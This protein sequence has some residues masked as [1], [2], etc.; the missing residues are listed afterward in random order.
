MGRDKT[1]VIGLDG[2]TFALLKL[3]LDAGVLPNI[4]SFIRNG[5]TGELE[6]VFPPMTGPG[7]VS[8]MTG[9]NPGMHSIFDFFDHSGDLGN[10]RLNSFLDIKSETVWSIISRA[11]KSV[12]LLN[13]P[14]TYPP[15]NINGF[16]VS[17]LLTPGS[18]TDYSYPPDLSG[19]LERRFGRLITEVPWQRYNGKTINQLINHLRDG[20]RQKKDYSIY[21]MEKFDPDIFMVVFTETDSIQHALWDVLTGDKTGRRS[22]CDH[23][24]DQALEYFRELDEA[25]GEIYRSSGE[26][27]NLFIISDHGFGPINKRIHLNAWLSRIGLLSVDRRK[28]IFHKILR[29]PLYALKRF[30]GSSGLKSLLKRKGTP[31][32]LGKSLFIDSLLNCVDW[33]NTKAFSG[34]RT[35]QGIYVNLEGR[36]PCGKVRPGDEYEKLRDH[37]IAELRG[38]LDIDCKGKYPSIIKK[39]EE[40]F[41]G[42][43]L[44]QAPDIVFA[45]QDF[46]CQADDVITSKIFEDRSWRIGTGTH[47]MEGLF[48][49]TG[50][51]IRKGEKT[52]GL[53]IIDIT[54]ILLYSLGLDIPD[55][56]DGKV[57]EGIFTDKYISYHPIKYTKN[58]NGH[59]LSENIVFSNNEEQQV[60]ERLT[61]LGYLD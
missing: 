42:P 61:G 40:V 6:T 18:K 45:L 39:K 32:S 57:H 27:T 26:N 59:S 12:G 15:P 21:L 55:D 52:K 11:G 58:K 19:E 43:Y 51:G 34:L 1:V 20:T 29:S 8:L 3:L 17:G 31:K 46:R 33:E 60:I 9:K 41:Q 36:F 25:V 35:E 5:T 54:P 30:A 4:S 47:R 49:A 10:R 50:D 37:I 2:A 56:I 44:D 13:L 16:A 28:Y 22:N 48:I 38:F 53:R 14:L 24:R 7:W 23:I